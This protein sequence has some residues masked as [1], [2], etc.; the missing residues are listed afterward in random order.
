MFGLQPEDINLIKNVM[1][2]YPVVQE[3]I[4]FGSRAKGTYKVGSDVDIA[5][6]GTGLESL[7]AQISAELNDEIPLP[8][9]FD[10]VDLDTLDNQ[11]LK[12]H[13]Q[14]VGIIF[15]SK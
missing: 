12:E 3:A 8:Y 5:L 7:T 4:L 14:R 10:V 9:C 11:A 1:K 6:K 15:Y 2:R 13:I